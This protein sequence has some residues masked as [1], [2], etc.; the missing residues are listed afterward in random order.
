MNL[1][2]NYK[3]WLKSLKEKIRSAQ[4]KASIAVNEEML[5]L[6]WDIGKSIVEK[7]IQFTWGSKIVEQMAK[8]LKKELSDTTGFSR[9]NLFA[10]R[11]FYQF[12]S[13]HLIE[14]QNNKP[15]LAT[16]SQL[17]QQVVGLIQKDENQIVQQVVG[18]LQASSILCKIPWGHHN[19]ILSKCKTIE[20][21]EFY[22]KQTIQ[23]NWSR[24]IL[25]IQIESKLIERQGKAIT[26]FE[27]T[28][29]KSQSDLAK[30]TLK[31]PYK[32]G[33]VTLES[34]VQELQLEK[35][36]TDNITHF[37]LELGKGFAFVGRQ[38][39]LLVGKKDRKI[40]LL[41]YHLKMHCYVVIDLKMGEF[42]P[43][44]AGKMNYY[45]SA[46]DKL[47]KTEEDNPSIGIILC[48][49][50]DNLEVE[51]ALQDFNKPMGISEFTFNELPENIKMNMP[52]IQELENEL[53][54]P[55]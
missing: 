46:V 34:E 5:L 11:K 1:D 45:L 19:V 39:P 22:I 14:N 13:Q 47:I 2:E 44:Y 35:S 24:N 16:N 48:K 9:S 38:Y 23:N 18:Q 41:F 8:D 43:E 15:D 32:F 53:N 4:I 27:V 42:E 28:L 50:K 52:T 36:L 29:P 54:N 3:I 51:F 49:S 33:F 12:Y 7:Q 25:E 37:L 21:A 40:D 17:V 20:E 10:M 26:N 55:K 31:D 30:E 6:Y